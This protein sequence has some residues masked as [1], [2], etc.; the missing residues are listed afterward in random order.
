MRTDRQTNLTKLTVAFRNFVKSALK[1]GQDIRTKTKNL[2]LAEGLTKQHR[3]IYLPSTF[4]LIILVNLPVIKQKVKVTGWTMWGSRNKGTFS[5][6]T[7]HT[8]T[9]AHS[10]FY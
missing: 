2:G 4:Q 3:C 8:G 7:L 9:R 6:S 10:A 5:S 1:T